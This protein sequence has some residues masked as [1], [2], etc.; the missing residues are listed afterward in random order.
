M[1]E[2]LERLLDEMD[3]LAEA[4]YRTDDVI[5][6]FELTMLVNK[7]RNIINMH[8]ETGED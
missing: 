7:F 8:H 1:I 4:T 3:H 2:K 6:P 5:F